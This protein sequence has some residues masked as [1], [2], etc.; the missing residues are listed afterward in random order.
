RRVRF[1]S[2]T[3]NSISTGRVRNV[4]IT[5]DV[6]QRRL[7]IATVKLDS[8]ETDGSRLT[9]AA[10]DRATA[11]ELRAHVLAGRAGAET[12]EIARLDPGWVRYAPAGLMPPLLGRVGLGLVFQVA[13]W[14][15]PVPAPVGW[16][17]ERS[18]RP[19]AA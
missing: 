12:S 3:T 8:R 11:E 6:V 15:N 2:S 4:E 17:R 7:G 5:A 10:L 18:G 13:S 19:P 1:L 14:L 16:R 9:L